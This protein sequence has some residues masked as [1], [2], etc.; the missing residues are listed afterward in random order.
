MKWLA[1]LA[2]LVG[3][4]SS[5]DTGPQP[6]F[7]AGPP[8][9]FYVGLATGRRAFKDSF[10]DKQAVFLDA[11]LG[12]LPP[13]EGP[14]VP[15]AHD[16]PRTY[17]PMG[18]YYFEVIEPTT[19]GPLSQDALECRRFH[20]NG[21]GVID[22]VYACAGPAHVQGR[23]QSPYRELGIAGGGITVQL[24]PYR[25]SATE[26]TEHHGAAVYLLEVTP[27]LS[28]PLGTYGVWEFEVQPPPPTECEVGYGGACEVRS[29]PRDHACC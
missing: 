1:A 3:C 13:P 7:E 27:V 20:V 4:Q 14:R 9:D 25:D 24:A 18:D 29:A 21:A 5:T 2:L 17:M 15:R 22:H 19:R 8:P 12:G 6:A 10:A 11:V 23:D 28:Y 26:S 16:G